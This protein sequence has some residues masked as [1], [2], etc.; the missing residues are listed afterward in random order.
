M[1]VLV[2]LQVAEFET[3]SCIVSLGLPVQGLNTRWTV[4][5]LLMFAVLVVGSCRFAD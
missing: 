1:I 5:D 4:S 3:V 2:I